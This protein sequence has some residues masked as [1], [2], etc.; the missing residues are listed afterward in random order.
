MA[1][2]R[3]LFIVR[4]VVVCHFGVKT[5]QNV[6]IALT[7]AVP[8]A[9]TLSV[10]VIFKCFNSE[11]VWTIKRQ[12]AAGSADLVDYGED[13]MGGNVIDQRNGE[14]LMTPFDRS[15]WAKY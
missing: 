4:H 14:T 7:V 6:I 1:L 13:E 11:Q 3:Y 8:L 12:K 5:T 15:S 2:A 9:M 10:Q